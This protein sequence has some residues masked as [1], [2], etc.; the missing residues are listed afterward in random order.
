MICLDRFFVNLAWLNI[1]PHIVSFNFCRFM[2]DYSPICLDWDL[3]EPQ[4]Y[5]IFQFEKS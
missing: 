4:E 1:Y 3:G 2:S 5:D